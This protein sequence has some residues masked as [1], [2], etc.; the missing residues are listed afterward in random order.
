MYILSLCPVVP[1]QT[2][3]TNTIEKQRFLNLLIESKYVFVSLSSFY[4]AAINYQPKGKLPFLS[5][6]RAAETKEEQ[7]AGHK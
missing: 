2:Q 6:V 1:P 7:R 5:E 4:A 3:L